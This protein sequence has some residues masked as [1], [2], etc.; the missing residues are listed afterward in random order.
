MTYIGPVNTWS[1][2]AKTKAVKGYAPEQN[3]TV[4]KPV[5]STVS[6]APLVDRRQSPDRRQAQRGNLVETRTGG[7]RRKAKRPKIDITI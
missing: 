6:V 2:T 4:S 7:D 3:L 5:E 1:L